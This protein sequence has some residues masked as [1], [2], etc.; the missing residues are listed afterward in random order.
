MSIPD[1]QQIEKHLN[2]IFNRSKNKS[3]E[4]L[5]IISEIKQLGYS[6]N[7]ILN[8][9][10][11]LIRRGVLY[12]PQKGK[13]KRISLNPTVNRPYDNNEDVIAE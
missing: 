3:I 13:I 7:T 12:E 2:A 5:Q 6:E 4:S 1:F 11:I 9:L 8:V 10:R